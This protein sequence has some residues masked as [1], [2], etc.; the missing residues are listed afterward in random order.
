MKAKG[1][2]I[3]SLILGTVGGI[4]GIGSLFIDPKAAE[5][6]EAEREKAFAEKYGLT[7]VGESKEGDR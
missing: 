4:C 6:D 7:P 1:W 2:K 3:L 5:F